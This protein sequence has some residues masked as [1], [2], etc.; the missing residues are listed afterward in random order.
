[1]TQ[2]KEIQIPSG[3]YFVLGDN[4]GYSSDSREWGLVKKAEIVGK[5]LLRYWPVDSLGIYPAAYNK[6]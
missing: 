5:V 4:R 3:E 6:Y 1:M 2:G